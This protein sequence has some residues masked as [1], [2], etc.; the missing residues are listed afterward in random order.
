MKM[1]KLKVPQL[2]VSRIG[3]REMMQEVFDIQPEIALPL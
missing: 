1:P 2:K 3:G